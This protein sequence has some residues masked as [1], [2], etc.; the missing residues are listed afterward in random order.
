M[1]C[2]RKG[3]KN[4][5]VFFPSVRKATALLRLFNC[6]VC[7][8]NKI[9]IKDYLKMIVL[10]YHYVKSGLNQHKVDCFNLIVLV[11]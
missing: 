9:S 5:A 10:V 2:I 1:C 11:F 4:V 7:L 8:C 3:I 6:F